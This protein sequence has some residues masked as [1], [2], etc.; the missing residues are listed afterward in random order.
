[1]EQ[2]I[3]E[4]C[5][6]LLVQYNL[7]MA[8]VESATAGE[9]TAT[10]SLTQQSGD[11]LKGGLICYDACIK[12]DLLKVDPAL[13]KEFTPESTEVTYEITKGLSHLIEADIHI[14][15][16]GLTR[17]GGSETIEKPVGTM[18]FCGLF[19]ENKIFEDRKVFEGSQEEIVRQA[20]VHTAYLLKKSLIK[21]NLLNNERN[22]KI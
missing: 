4:E 10:F 14:G 1:M 12:E 3:F 20:T 8:C 5:R 2:N 13:L 7:T 18:F 16:T 17:P 15:I 19:G 6:E 11:F 21:S 22:T 9:L